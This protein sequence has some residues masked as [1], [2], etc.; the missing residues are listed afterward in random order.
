MPTRIVDAVTPCVLFPA[1]EAGP[2]PRNPQ[3]ATTTAAAMNPFRLNIAP[4]S[5]RDTDA[6]GRRLGPKYHTG[7]R[8]APYEMSAVQAL[9]PGCRLC[10]IRTTEPSAIWGSQS[11]PGIGLGPQQVFR[12]PN[13]TSRP[14]DRSGSDNV[15]EIH[16]LESRVG[17]Y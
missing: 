10:G 7:S 4:P 14:E 15:G 13:A 11:P 16:R 9:S 17:R 6:R 5:S 8:S 2:I 12:S 3:S 1:A